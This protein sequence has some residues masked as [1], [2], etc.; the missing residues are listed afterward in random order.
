M[1]NLSI[2]FL[3][4]VVSL[5]L[6]AQTIIE[7]PQFSATTAEYVKIK[8]IELHD[9]VT[10]VDFEVTYFPNW[11]IRVLASETYF[12][13]SNGEEKYYVKRAEGIQLEEHHW[14]PESGVNNYT[15]YFPPIGKDIEKV[16]FLEES[17]KI[18]DIELRAPRSAVSIIPEE[19]Q[20]NWL[21][22]DGS[23]AWDYGI[24]KDKVI[25]KNKVWNSVLIT[26]K[27][28][29][30]RLVLKDGMEQEELFVKRKKDKLLIGSSA[31]L[32][33]EYS[34]TK[35]NR[36]DYVLD[37]DEGFKLPVLKEDSAIY[38]G[39]IKGYHPKMGKTGM[40][41]VNNIIT[42]AQNSHLVEISP[43]GSFE[44]RVPMIHPQMVFIDMLAVRE[45]VFLEPGGET[46]HFIDFSE[47]I[48]PF[49]TQ[50]DRNKRIRKSLFMGDAAKIN[51]DLKATE[52]INFWD[53]AEVNERI[54]DMTGEEYKAYCLDILNKEKEA[55]DMFLQT[56]HLSQKSLQLN[57]MQIE[58]RAY[59]NILSY[60][61]LKASVYRRKNEIPNH[62][63]EIPLEPGIFDPSYY[64]FINIAELD[65]PV[66]LISNEYPILI[67][68]IGFAE[69]I[70]PKINY[71]FL[72]MRDLF[73]EKEIVLTDEEKSVIDE[74][75]AC[76]EHQCIDEILTSNKETWAS[77]MEKH[78]ALVASSSKDSY[79][80]T[81]M[82]NLNKYFGLEQ[83]LV[84]D[85]MYAQHEASML[86]GMQKPFSEA[87]KNRIRENI[88]NTFIAE[89]LIKESDVRERLR[90]ETFEANK[91]KTGYVINETPKAESDK[92][93][94]AIVEKYKG[95]IVYVDFWATWCGPCRG[96]IER[97]KSLKE[98]LK[99]KEIE[100][101]YITNPTSPLDT[102]SMMVP[103]IKGE[104][105]RL[106]TDEWNYLASRFN[107]NGIPHYVLVD[108]DG[109]IIND[110]V[111]LY[112]NRELKKMFDQYLEN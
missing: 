46:F 87:D 102:W 104:H 15:L 56:G 1:K 103:N 109:I 74:L 100:F 22:N 64:D 86:T 76:S 61:M 49:K 4:T 90:A 73:I 16:D 45:N 13:N 111:R 25:Y 29:N 5:S 39:Y 83:G 12:Q 60:N 77:F 50:R 94:D 80:H 93:F 48:E 38:K 34:K 98:E 89:Y 19:I 107:I 41:F 53:Y 59:Q 95:K 17:W 78:G 71:S 2:L 24:Y 30:H 70:K 11:W 65:N 101:V 36:Q 88:S 28:K 68:R 105:Y 55:L 79:H 6:S 43:D 97:I 42:Q 52:Y 35:T 106:S 32:L 81:R 69:S 7:N 8:K 62:Q 37:N 91:S 75:I 63:Q 67:N 96:G 57:E 92:L 82:R 20:G 72:A 3:L 10:K 66:S 51:T 112:S 9:T 54:L 84:S 31:N 40:V 58:Q 44:C 110:N 33:H 99:D 108:K 85:I 14:T 47:Y 27:G 21:K 26:S 18:F 23:N